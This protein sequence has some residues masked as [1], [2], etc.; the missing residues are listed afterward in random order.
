MNGG[1]EGEGG[2]EA[3]VAVEIGGAPLRVMPVPRK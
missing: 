3:D 1:G 2:G